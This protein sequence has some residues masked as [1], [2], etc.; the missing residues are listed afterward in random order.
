MEEGPGE[1]VQE[2]AS[3]AASCVGFRCQDRP[4]M[5]QVNLILEGLLS[6]GNHVGDN[7]LAMESEED[8]R[9]VLDYLS[10]V[11][12]T[13]TGESDKWYGAEEDTLMSVGF[14]SR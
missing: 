9:L 2:V 4:T 13:S 11:E 10:P 6:S 1:E 8:N 14:G 12:G 3:L 5:R 7:I